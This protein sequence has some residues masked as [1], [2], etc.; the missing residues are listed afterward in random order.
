MS[1]K[2]ADLTVTFKNQVTAVNHINL[3]ISNGIYGLLGEN[4]AGKTTLMRVLTTVLKPTGGTVSLDGILYSEGNYEKIQQKIGYL[5]QEIDLY[6]NLSV[7][8]CLEYMGELSG[9]PQQ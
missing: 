2:I 1:I 3:E 4:G 5:P 7:Q 8:E 6:P 9:I